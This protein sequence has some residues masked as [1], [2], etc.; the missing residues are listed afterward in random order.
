VDEERPETQEVFFAVMEDEFPVLALCNYNWKAKQLVV[1][2]CYDRYPRFAKRK[3]GKAGIAEGIVPTKAKK[4]GGKG[5]GKKKIINAIPDSHKTD[6]TAQQEQKSQLHLLR[7]SSFL[8]AYSAD[9]ISP[10]PAI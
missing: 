7:S 4:N 1:D 8:A 2:F 5:K 10:D 9:D 6:S 3:S